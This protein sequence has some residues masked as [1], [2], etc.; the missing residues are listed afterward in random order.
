MADQSRRLLPR[1]IRFAELCLVEPSA[2]RAAIR[3]GYSRRSARNQAYRLLANDDIRRRIAGGLAASRARNEARRERILTLLERAFG[4][5]MEQGRLEPALRALNAQV[6]VSGL[7][8][9]TSRLSGAQRAAAADLWAADAAD[10]PR[11]PVGRPGAGK[12]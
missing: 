5:A 3:A 10:G 12:L 9:R 6:E 8:L 2:T 7:L 4:A 11:S 1:Q